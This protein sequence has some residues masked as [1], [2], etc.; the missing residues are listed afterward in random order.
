MKTVKRYSKKREAILNTICSTDSHP[1]VEWIYA[2]LKPMYPDLSLGTVYRNISQFK[3]AGKVI[4]V[5]VVGGQERYDGN[6]TPHLHFICKSCG[7]VADI[8]QE[9]DNSELD[10]RISRKYGIRVDHHETVFYGTCK[11]CL[12]GQ[13]ADSDD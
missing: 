3:E 1:S 7:C 5:G 2:E 8:S 9:Q 6:V 10:A 4:C 11:E 13:G 12:D